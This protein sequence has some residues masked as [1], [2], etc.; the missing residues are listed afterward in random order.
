MSTQ[1]WLSVLKSRPY[2]YLSENR[3]GI[4]IFFW[5]ISAREEGSAWFSLFAL[6][7]LVYSPSTFGSIFLSKVAWVKGS[8]VAKAK[9]I[10]LTGFLLLLVETISLLQVICGFSML[11]PSKESWVLG[12]EVVLL[13][14]S[15][16][17]QIVGRV[18]RCGKSLRRLNRRKSELKQKD[19]HL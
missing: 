3:Q 19:I 1:I 11:S 4:S 18:R 2:C 15:P 5:F 12:M 10:F 7:V 16:T 9:L 17:K 14:P 13:D 8:L 6:R